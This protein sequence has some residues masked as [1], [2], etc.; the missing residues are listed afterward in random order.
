MMGKI[1]FQWYF[2]DFSSIFF[3]PIPNFQW[4]FV[5]TSTNNKLTFSGYLFEKNFNKYSLKFQKRYEFFN[6]YNQK[7]FDS[8]DM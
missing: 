8:T 3:H 7:S 6:K 5:E 2:I 1:I 4:I